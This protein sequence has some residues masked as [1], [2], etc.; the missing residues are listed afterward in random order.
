VRDDCKCKDDFTQSV[1]R[2]HVA[3]CGECR[4]DE[5]GD[6]EPCEEYQRL[7]MADCGG[8]KDRA[9]AVWPDG[10]FEHYDSAKEEKEGQPIAR[11]SGNCVEALR[12]KSTETERMATNDTPMPNGIFITMT[13]ERQEKIE[14][15]LGVLQGGLIWA[16][17]EHNI[18]KVVVA[19]AV[20]QSLV[21]AVAISGHEDIAQALDNM[22]STVFVWP[23]DD[24]SEEV[25]EQQATALAKVV[26]NAI[27]Y[28]GGLAENRDEAL[29]MMLTMFANA[30]IHYMA[31]A[32][33][34]QSEEVSAHIKKALET[35]R[36][37]SLAKAMGEPKGGVN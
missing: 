14:E 27:Q 32:W 31:D 36:D 28:I 10:S 4:T 13:P 23:R 15:A 30:V 8:R 25:K 1:A 29:M 6:L 17:L 26:G 19:H 22:F 12:S 16:Q 3:V 35:A 9:C 21:W 2:L 24:R 18:H 5:D 20:T 37:W 7:F 11:R 34:E 33:G